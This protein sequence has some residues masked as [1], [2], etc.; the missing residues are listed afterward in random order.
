MISLTSPSNP[1]SKENVGS[2][3]DAI[4][5][6]SAADPSDLAEY[7]PEIVLKSFDELTMYPQDRMI[8]F[9]DYVQANTG[10]AWW[11]TIACTTIL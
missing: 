1:S 6:V 2:E 4:G 7:V 8:V 5:D 3:H 9:L 10:L 11:E